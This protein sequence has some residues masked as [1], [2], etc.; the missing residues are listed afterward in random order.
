MAAELANHARGIC[1]GYVLP[2]H[3]ANGGPTEGVDAV[4]ELVTEEPTAGLFG[5]SF[6]SSSADGATSLRCSSHQVGNVTGRGI[7]D[8]GRPQRSVVRAA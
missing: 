6:T 1:Y 5:I 2:S 3:L 4:S 8:A 7:I